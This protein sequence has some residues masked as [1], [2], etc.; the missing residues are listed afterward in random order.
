LLVERV[1][2]SLKTWAENLQIRG[3]KMCLRIRYL[4]MTTNATNEQS[5]SSAGEVLTKRKYVYIL[6]IMKEQ[7]NQEVNMAKVLEADL[8]D[9]VSLVCD[10]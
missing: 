6:L 9:L 2:L 7:R 8:P 4:I 3:R 5:F 1:G 10:L